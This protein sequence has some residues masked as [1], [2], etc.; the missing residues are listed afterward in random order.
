MA[1]MRHGDKPSTKIVK[2]DYAVS[3]EPTNDIAPNDMKDVP[4][5]GIA[6]NYNYGG[7]SNYGGSKS[8]D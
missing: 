4:Y 3:A 8:R 5:K 7:A 2:N 1:I 6:D